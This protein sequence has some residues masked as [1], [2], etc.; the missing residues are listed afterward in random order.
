MATY[1]TGRRQRALGL[2]L[3]VM[4]ARGAV[5]TPAGAQPAA[6]ESLPVDLPDGPARRG[7]DIERFSNVGNGWFETFYVERTEPLAAVLDDGRVAGDTRVLV[8]DT[9]TGRLALLTDQMAY[10]HIAQG[11]AGGKDWMATF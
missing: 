10:H 6:R 7:F 2:A 4:V 1:P 3:A 5:P 8:L 9:A 11:R